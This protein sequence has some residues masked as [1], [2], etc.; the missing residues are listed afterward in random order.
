MQA[1]KQVRYCGRQNPDQQDTPQHSHFSAPHQPRPSLQGLL[2]STRPTFT[3]TFTAHARQHCSVSEI[4][5][6]YQRWPYL[7]SVMALTGKNM[8]EKSLAL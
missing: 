2:G 3:A 8:S 7:S 1:G 5:F 4:V 6:G